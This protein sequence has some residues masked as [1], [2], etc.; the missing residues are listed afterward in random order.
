MPAPRTFTPHVEQPTACVA[1]Q[2]L[3]WFFFL[4]ESI[5]QDTLSVAAKITNEN[6]SPYQVISFIFYLKT[7]PILVGNV[8]Y[9]HPGF[10]S[11]KIQ[12][13]VSLKDYIII[14]YF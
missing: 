13:D 1:R 12:Y 10:C 4:R 14:I 2:V 3:F 5:D 9:S 6:R 7:I 8:H 11:T